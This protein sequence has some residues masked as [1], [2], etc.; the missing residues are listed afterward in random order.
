M[1]RKYLHW[2]LRARAQPWHNAFVDKRQGMNS[3]LQ[4]YHTIARSG[5][6]HA[7]EKGSM[8]CKIS[9]S[10]HG[11]QHV[12]KSFITGHTWN[13]N[14]ETKE[15]EKKKKERR[16]F[17]LAWLAPVKWLCNLF[18]F[19][20]MSSF[21]RLWSRSDQWLLRLTKISMI[22]LDVLDANPAVLKNNPCFRMMWYI[23]NA[24]RLTLHQLYNGLRRCRQMGLLVCA[25]MYI[26]LF[27]TVLPLRPGQKKK[28]VSKLHR[29]LHEYIMT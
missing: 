18:C 28:N 13:N 26:A 23:G 22:F 14:M 1:L 2:S 15:K 12:K 3:V 11:F 6:S 10:S 29:S 21:Y 25:H 5:F 9:D 24:K 27:L 19:Q 16:K 7:N 8:T 20:C 17:E 4:T